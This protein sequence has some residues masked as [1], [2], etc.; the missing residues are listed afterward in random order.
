MPWQPK[1]PAQFV[2]P[3]VKN[4]RA[5]LERDA[6]AS[7]AWAGAPIQLSN[8][9]WFGTAQHVEP[10]FPFCLVLADTS[11]VEGSDDASYINETHNI[12]ILIGVNGNDPDRLADELFI[13][14]NAV[15]SIIREA[16]WPDLLEGIP[17][18]GYGPCVLETGRH[19]YAQ[20]QRR[21]A[22]QQYE[23]IAELSIKISY[24]ESVRGII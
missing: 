24:F 4:L 22:N 21:N 12:A 10:R 13:R 14:V 11:D 5:I 7:L 9:A 19:N 20:F 8:F 1:I 23:H 15:D 6:P 16:A 2:R 18:A 17:V 3:L